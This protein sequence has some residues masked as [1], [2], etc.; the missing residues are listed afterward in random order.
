[1]AT[2]SEIRQE[3][4]KMHDLFSP[5]Y[6]TARIRF[7]Q[8]V[9]KVRGRLHTLP[10]E[11][12]GPG[13]EPLGIDIGW[14]GAERPKRILLHSSGL[15]G[16]EGFAGSAIQLQLLDRVPDLPR[17]AALILVHILNPYGMAW[18]RRV[19]EDNVDLNRNFII[20]GRHS[21]APQNYEDINALLSPASPPRRDLFFLRAV[22]FVLRYGLTPLRQAIA[23]GQYEFPKGL[24]FGGN[25]IEPGP[26]Q[27]R[28]FLQE[29]FASAEHIVAID[30]HTGLGKY[31]QDTLLVEPEAFGRLRPLFGARVTPSVSSSGPAYR[32]RGGIH[33]MIT[34]SAPQARV[35]CVCQEFGSY[36][37]IRVLNALRNE[38]RWHFHG[39]GTLDHW[40]KRRL[41]KM[42]CPADDAWRRAVLDRGGAL[43]HTAIEQIRDNK[44]L[45]GNHR[46]P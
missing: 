24:F 32:I 19:N 28:A 44:Q 3:N 36:S 23:G 1:M 39:A 10:L 27:Y 8:A 40:T 45:S 38:N 37:A 13:G 14:F 9:E 31:A 6:F 5:D 43:V 7:H 42:F 33:P 35:D 25:R 18:L 11:A 16:V 46:I 4:F 34:A 30:V 41:M 29:S 22:P 26:S 2:E 21:G 20:E 15:H 12:R 17:D